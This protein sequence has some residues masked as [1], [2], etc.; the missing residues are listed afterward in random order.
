MSK[1]HNLQLWVKGIG[2]KYF[3]QST[4]VWAAPYATCKYRK[5]HE[6]S[7]I[8]QKHFYKIVP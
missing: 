6:C 2:G 5:D 4:L 1:L 8:T 7:T 3:H